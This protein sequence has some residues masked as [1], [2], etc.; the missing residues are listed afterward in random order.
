MMR[1]IRWAAGGWDGQAIAVLLFGW[2]VA[3]YVTLT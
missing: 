3:L 1:Q 2:F